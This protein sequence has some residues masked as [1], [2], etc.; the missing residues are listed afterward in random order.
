MGAILTVNNELATT[1]ASITEALKDHWEPKFQRPP[2]D[3]QLLHDR[4]DNFNQL[5]RQAAPS[6]TARATQWTL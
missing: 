6:S 5:S 4:L 3:G 1:P 2:M